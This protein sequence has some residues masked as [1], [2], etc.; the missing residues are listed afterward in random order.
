[1]DESLK[2]KRP[3]CNAFTG[4][5]P[6]SFQRSIDFQM[7]VS[8]SWEGER[9]TYHL[10]LRNYFAGCGKK[11]SFRENSVDQDPVATGIRLPLSVYKALLRAASRNIHDTIDRESNE[12][13]LSGIPQVYLPRMTLHKRLD[14]PPT[15]LNWL[16]R[17]DAWMRILL[18]H[19]VWIFKGSCFVIL[20]FLFLFGTSHSFENPES[21][22]RFRKVTLLSKIELI[23]EV[24]LM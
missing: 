18:C 10:L 23:K 1:M 17:L 7:I 3:F 9:S 20:Y 21:A 24:I 4:K 2:V 15:S 5:K 16:G 11:R 8:V 14:I 22:F 19:N 12:Y 13:R 6:F